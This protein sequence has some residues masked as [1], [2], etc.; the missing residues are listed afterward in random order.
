MT[1]ETDLAIERERTRRTI[2]RGVVT[3]AIV[4]IFFGAM[5]LGAAVR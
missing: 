3:V 2:I 1:N 4:L 5:V